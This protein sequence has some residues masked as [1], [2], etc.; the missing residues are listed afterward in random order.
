VRDGLVIE[1]I[2][3]QGFWTNDMGAASAF[4][5]L[6]RRMNSGSARTPAV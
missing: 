6:F 5:H 1:L 3:C 4:G 2:E